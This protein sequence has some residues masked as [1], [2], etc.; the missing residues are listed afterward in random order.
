MK[1]LGTVIDTHYL[2]GW[3]EWEWLQDFIKE[4]F[5][6]IYDSG[7]VYSI[8]EIYK[9]VFWSSELYRGFLQ[10]CR[11]HDIPFLDTEN[12]GFYKQTAMLIKF[13][14][15]SQILSQA[16]S[17]QVRDLLW[18]QTESVEIFTAHN[19]IPGT[20]KTYWLWQQAACNKYIP[21]NNKGEVLYYLS[22]EDEYYRVYSR[23]SWIHIVDTQWNVIDI[24]ADNIRKRDIGKR[25]AQYYRNI[26]QITSQSDY[27]NDDAF[28]FREAKAEY[29]E[30]TWVEWKW[31]K[32]DMIHFRSWLWNQIRKYERIFEIYKKRNIS[33][34]V[35]NT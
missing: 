31:G 16:V 32:L 27:T 9:R 22:D 15:I 2:D 3:F 20:N 29:I 10:F 19:I 26:L 13:E 17:I 11:E 6:W 24:V 25:R 4:Y 30:E 12:N 14:E 1:R 28:I 34:A 5:Y 33:V 7:R 21:I 35:D 8:D 23:K 18:L